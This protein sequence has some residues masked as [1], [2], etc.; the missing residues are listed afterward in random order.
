[1]DGRISLKFSKYV[2]H[3]PGKKTALRVTPGMQT[4]TAILV[5]QNYKFCSTFE[6]KKWL[7]QC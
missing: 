4:D 3:V 5:H 7:N 1:M 6:V 2:E